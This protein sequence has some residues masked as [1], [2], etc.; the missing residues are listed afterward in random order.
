MYTKCQSAYHVGHSMETAILHVHSDVMC[1]LDERRYV[2]FIMLDLSA[3][4]G[5]I[6]YDFLLHRFCTKFAINRTALKSFS[7]Y[8]NCKTQLVVVG[9]VMSELC[10]IYCGLPHGSVWDLCYFE[11]QDAMCSNWDSYV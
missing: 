4:F 10:P 5:T 7:S 2:I 1:S 9:T 3:A 8:L 11:L 6:D